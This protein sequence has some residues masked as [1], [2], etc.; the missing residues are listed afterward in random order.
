LC[1]LWAGLAVFALTQNF[2]PPLWAT[3][4]LAGI[5]FYFL[6]A[7]LSRLGSRTS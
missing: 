3:Y 4:G 6:I 5:A 2:T 1:L 7:G